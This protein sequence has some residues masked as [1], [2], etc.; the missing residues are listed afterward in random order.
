MIEIQLAKIKGFY[1]TNNTDKNCYCNKSG[2]HSI[3]EKPK[4]DL[5]GMKKS[6]KKKRNIMYLEVV[7]INNLKFPLNYIIYKMKT[8]KMRRM[9]KLLIHS[10]I[11]IKETSEWLTLI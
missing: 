10:N 6:K 3:I 2:L 11:N 8:K 4:V 1:K 7:S 9:K 5:I